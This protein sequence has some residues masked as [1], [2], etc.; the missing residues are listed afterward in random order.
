MRPLPVVCDDLGTRYHGFRPPNE[1]ALLRT[2]SLVEFEMATYSPGIQAEAR[3]LEISHQ[4]T[5]VHL[6]LR[7]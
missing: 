6:A 7:S 5:A 3:R 1:R 4:G 2:A